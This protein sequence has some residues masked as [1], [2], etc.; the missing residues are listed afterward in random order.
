MKKLKL[1][2]IFVISLFLLQNCD[3]D[4]QDISILNKQKPIKTDW[5][6]TEWTN[7]VLDPC[8]QVCLVAGQH[9]YV[10]TVDIAES[11]GDLYVTYNIT[12]SGVYLEEV[13]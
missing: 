11:N 12:E 10:G 13:H 9:M 1:I 5:N 6:L 3:K 7:G 4:S 8:K 2:T